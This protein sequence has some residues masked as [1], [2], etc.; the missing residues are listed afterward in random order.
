[1]KVFISYT[2]ED[3]HHNAW[4]ESL[5][6]RLRTDGIETTLDQWDLGLGDEITRF[7]EAG[8]RDHDRVLVICTPE[9]KRKA[10]SR[11]GG[12][13]YE[14]SQITA[15]ILSQS[16]RGKVVPVLRKGTRAD[17]TPSYLS[18]I[19]GADLCEG[20]PGRYEAEYRKLRQDLSGARRTAPPVG[21]A[22]PKEKF[23]DFKL[24]FLQDRLMGRAWRVGPGDIRYENGLL[25][26]Q[27]R[28]RYI[29]NTIIENADLTGTSYWITFFE[30]AEFEDA[31]QNH[32]WKNGDIVYTY[33]EAE[34]WEVIQR[35]A[36]GLN[37]R[38]GRLLG[39]EHVQHKVMD[40]GDIGF[41]YVR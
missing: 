19:N 13:G 14:T 32:I 33:S 4:V 5:A 15:E 40:N 29:V 17:A 28:L 39:P 25:M 7:M 6:A 24:S 10:D 35:C 16:K 30:G 20:N 12:A 18:G 23:N 21:G 38:L 37:F 2:W 34:R 41:R 22:V 36:G 11:L 1:M 9:Y 27:E 8:V 3:E 31:I 26:D